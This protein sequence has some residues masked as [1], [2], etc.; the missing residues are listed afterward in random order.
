MLKQ[1][2]LGNEAIAAG[3]QA[4]GVKVISSYPGTPSTEI[5]EAASAGGQIYCEWAPNEKVG[6]EVAVG[7][8]LAGVRAMSCMK[9]VGLNVAADPLFTAAYTGVNG[10]LVVV[11]ADDPGMHSSQ[12]EQDSRHYARAA[13]LP[14]LEPADSQECQDF[15]LKAF[16]LS[17][18]F[19]TPVLIR[20]TTRVAHTR[21]PVAAAPRQEPPKRPYEKNPDKYVMMPAMARKRHQLVEERLLALAAWGNET[22]VRLDGGTDRSLGFV[23]SGVV[24]QYVREAFP[25]APVLK[26]DQVW[27]LPVDAIRRFAAG[28]DRLIV[29]EELDPVIETELKAAGIACEGKALLGLLGEYSPG[30]I[31]QA[32][33]DGQEAGLQQDP[34]VAVRPPILCAGCP[35][36]GLFMALKRLKVIVTGDIGCYTLAALSPLNA[37]DSCLCMGASIGM[38]HGMAKAT[39][40]D[41]ASKTVAVIGDSTFLHSGITGLLNSVYN[42][43]DMTLVILDNSI[44]GMTGHQQNPSTGRDIRLGQAPAVNLDSLCRVLGAESV[45]EVDPTDPQASQAVIAQ[46]LKRPGVSVVIARCPCALIPQG[47]G[48]CEAVVR[49]DRQACTRCGACIRIMCPALTADADG[50]P[51]ID[52]ASCNGCG[53]CIRV[54]RFD[55]LKP[56]GADHDLNH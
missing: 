26:L 38:A 16:D 1:M 3:A 8:S 9:H 45:T 22:G 35:H 40:G 13:K 52:E 27:P 43:S 51:V 12:N 14:L 28:V 10:G 39:D 5:T 17:E 25:D 33:T 21:S 31:R 48:S 54:C 46:A 29:A 56:K 34:S 4:A 49:L 20:L 41:L 44:T 50:Y 6:L 23:S 18:A 47:R 2:L 36:R 42:Q 7:A 11:V 53:L 37:M 30:R 19:D 55:A 32:L 24:Y 15:V